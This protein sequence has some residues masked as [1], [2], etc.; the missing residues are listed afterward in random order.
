MSI[1]IHLFYHVIKMEKKLLVGLAFIT[2]VLSLQSITANLAAPEDSAPLA[3]Y[4]F[5]DDDDDDKQSKGRGKDKKNDKHSGNSQEEE[6]KDLIEEIAEEIKKQ[7]QNIADKT[8]ETIQKIIPKQEELIIEPIPQEVPEREVRERSVNTNRFSE[9]VFA[10]FEKDVLALNDTQT[11]ILDAKNFPYGIRQAEAVIYTPLNITQIRPLERIGGDRYYGTWSLNITDLN[12]GEY[13]L[14]EVNLYSEEL[15]PGVFVVEDR[16]FYVIN[17]SDLNA[18]NLSLVYSTLERSRVKHNTNVVLKIDA[19][20]FS[21]LKHAEASVISTKGEEMIVPLFLVTGDKHYGTWEGN[22]FVTEPDTT[23]SV[24]SITLFNN[25]ES[26]TYEI[27]DR[28]IYVEAVPY[29]AP[30]PPSPAEFGS[31]RWIRHQIQS[32]FFPTFLGFIIML[33]I[34]M[35][36]SIS[37][38]QKE[39]NTHYTK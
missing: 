28:K 18:T 9:L 27:A 19:S 33:V 10:A 16:Q 4:R 39:E 34:V 5:D 20:D 29:V 1:I 6:T 37:S 3:G 24:T 38:R 2:L 15:R 12:A 30:P 35:L 26:K 36:A 7:S 32:P 8:Q 17:E 22:I 11:L 23:Y 14:K 25:D 13:I 21:G 31:E